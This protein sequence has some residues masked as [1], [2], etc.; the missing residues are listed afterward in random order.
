MCSVCGY[1]A[2]DFWASFAVDQNGPLSPPAVRAERARWLNAWVAR[3]T[4][5]VV[6]RRTQEA[7]A[8]GPLI[9]FDMGAARG[10]ADA[11][12]GLLS[13]AGIKAGIRGYTVSS[14]TGAMRFCACLYN[15][16]SHIRNRSP[17]LCHV[18]HCQWRPDDRKVDW[19]MW[20][21]AWAWN[22]VM[23]DERPRLPERVE[24]ADG[25]WLSFERLDN[26]K[27]RVSLEEVAAAA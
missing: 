1:T 16:V 18:L 13:G 26:D 8:A 24:L 15:V 17:H 19:A 23:N 9:Q 25:R 12:S 3:A 4:Q 11:P 5:A 20:G 22:A 21:A 7:G 10:G 14:P 6:D 27:V 2:N